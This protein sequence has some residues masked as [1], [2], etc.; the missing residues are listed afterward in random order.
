MSSLDL[1]RAPLSPRYGSRVLLPLDRRCYPLVALE[2][3]NVLTIGQASEALGLSPRQLRRR[4]DATRPLLASYIRRGEKNRLLLDGSAIELLRAIEDRRANGY[5]IEQALSAV[6]D[7]I[8][9]NNAGKQEPTTGQLAGNE[10]LLRQLIDEK[11]A[12]IHALE[13]EV[14]FLRRRV[15]ELTPLALPRR[16]S[17][18]AWF[19]GR[20]VQ[21]QSI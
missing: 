3:V 19:R 8:G 5:T 10:D 18:F 11:D 13:S 16:R 14:A 4:L 2:V 21:G 12:R 9:G 15:E 7:S 20:S 17:W 1:L 6:A